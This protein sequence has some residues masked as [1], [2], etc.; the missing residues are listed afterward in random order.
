MVLWREWYSPSPFGAREPN[1]PFLAFVH[2]LQ[3]S[4]IDITMEML[5]SKKITVIPKDF[6]KY[7]WKIIHMYELN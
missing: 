3:W 1:T 7:C 6:F 4:I 2:V 5:F